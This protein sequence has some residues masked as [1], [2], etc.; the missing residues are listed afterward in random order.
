LKNTENPDKNIQNYPEK[1][2]GE[3]IMPKYKYLNL[4]M[5]RVRF[6]LQTFEP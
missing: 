4:T 3:K 6:F 1:I 5:V 2:W